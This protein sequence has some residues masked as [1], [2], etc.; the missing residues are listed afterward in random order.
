MCWNTL[1]PK[2]APTTTRAISCDA[3]IEDG[4]CEFTGDECEGEGDALD[5]WVLNEACDCVPV[6]DR[7]SEQDLVFDLFPNPNEGAF[8]I[9]SNVD[10]GL[11]KVRSADGRLVHVAQLQALQHGVLVNL[12]LSNGMYLMEL[13]SE[14][15]HQAR[16]VVVQR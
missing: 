1:A 2:D 14:G 5:G 10:Q 7:L 6:T 3:G 11:L 9:M 8:R 16:R 13:Y 12:N 15:F 4:S